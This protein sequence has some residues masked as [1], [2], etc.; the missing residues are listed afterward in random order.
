MFVSCSKDWKVISATNVMNT[1]NGKESILTKEEEIKSAYSL[2]TLPAVRDSF[3]LHEFNTTSVIPVYTF[4]ICAGAFAEENDF[5]YNKDDKL[6]MFN[7]YCRASYLKQLDSFNIFKTAKLAL[8]WFK[9]HFSVAP[10]N[11]YDFVFVPGLKMIAMENYGCITFDDKFLDPTQTSIKNSYFHYL[12]VHELV[13]TWFGNSVTPE[14]W[15]DLW[16]NEA[17]A[18]FLS[19]LCLKQLADRSPDEMGEFSNIWLL[20]NKQKAKGIIYDQFRTTHKVRD[21]VEDTAHS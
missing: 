17:F 15:D 11:K 14:W 4:A 3:A 20:F 12:I 19:Y 9:E 7:I 1:T 2:S 21:N 6:P 18:T 16:L 5:S 10:E 8:G 13:H